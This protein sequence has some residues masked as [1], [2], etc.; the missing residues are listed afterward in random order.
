[1][2]VFKIKQPPTVL[3]LCRWTVY[4][5]IVPVKSPYLTLTHRKEIIGADI[6]QQMPGQ[7]YGVR[8]ELIFSNGAHVL[9]M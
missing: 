1:M 8:V 3:Q 5:T 7:M 2:F 9:N 4:S 6:L